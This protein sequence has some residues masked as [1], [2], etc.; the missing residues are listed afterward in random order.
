M[1]WSVHSYFYYT[2]ASQLFVNNTKRG[3][4]VD[5]LF[6]YS[7]YPYHINYCVDPIILYRSKWLCPPL[8]WLLLWISPQCKCVVRGTSCTI[9]RPDWN[10]SGKLGLK[11]A[12]AF[13]VDWAPAGLKH[14]AF[15]FW[16]SLGY[17]SFP[18][19]YWL[20]SAILT[21]YVLIG[22]VR[23]SL[24]ST[25]VSASLGYRYF[26]LSY[27]LHSANF[28]FLVGMVSIVKVNFI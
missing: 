15:W 20:R 7:K 10:R 12:E 24:L 23:L 6:S 5:V 17:P 21:F 2:L 8:A 14:Q 4:L 27:W 26:L 16:C 28:Y 1:E 19:S 3:K 13:L 25:V 11:V 18:L 9:I 22:F